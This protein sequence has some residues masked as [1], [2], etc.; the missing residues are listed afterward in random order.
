MN[1]ISRIFRI[2]I[3]K[4]TLA[5]VARSGEEAKIAKVREE[6]EKKEPFKEP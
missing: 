5:P 3:L 2:R 4:R 1:R 6:S